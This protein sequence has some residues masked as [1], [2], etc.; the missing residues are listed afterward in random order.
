MRVDKAGGDAV[1]MRHLSTMSALHRLQHHGREYLH[2][3]DS[4]VHSSER[5][6]AHCVF[7]LGSDGDVDS[8]GVP[9]FLE[10]SFLGRG[11]CVFWVVLL[12]ILRFGLRR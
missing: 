9:E 4:L 1:A 11:G 3:I 8:L 2:S 6:V 10:S 5:I 7:V 12:F